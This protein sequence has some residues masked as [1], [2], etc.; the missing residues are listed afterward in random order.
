MQRLQLVELEDLPWIPSAIRNAVTGYLQVMI[1][2]S[3]AYGAI[4]PHLAAAVRASGATRI[5]DLC[6][7]G[8]GPWRRI[9]AA[10][11]AEGV[12]VPILLT[13]RYP[14]PGAVEA[15]GGAGRAAEFPALALHRDAV[16]AMHVPETLGG[17]RTMFTAFHHFP[18]NAARAVLRDAVVHGVPIAVF[19]ATKRNAACLL[20]TLLT[21]II[22]LLVMPRVRPMRWTHLLF[23]YVIP[24]VPLMVVWDGIVSCL[25]TYDV[26]ELRALAGEA[27]PDGRFVWEAG[28]VHRRGPIPVTYL[29]GTPRP[30]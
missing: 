2:A 5:V 11:A 19:E 10:L 17:L 27:D 23:T 25:R 12:T 30:R 21:P 29:V 14:N 3:D 22:T 13:D 8:G 7:G 18:P 26:A 24:V 9:R 6:S 15:A 28:E 16:D 4:V 20:F 1:D